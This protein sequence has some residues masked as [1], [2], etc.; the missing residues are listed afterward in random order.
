MPSSLRRFTVFKPSEM[1]GILTTMLEGD[2]GI[3]VRLI[4]HSLHVER[5]DFGGNRPRHNL[6]DFAQH[7]A[8]GLARFGDQARI[9]R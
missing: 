7:G 3:L 9:R 4:E 6:N 8:K 5:C 2:V 1:S